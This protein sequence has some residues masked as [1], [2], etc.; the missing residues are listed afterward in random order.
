[1]ERV[2]LSNKGK[3]PKEEFA[4]LVFSWSL[5]D[6]NNEDLYKNRPFDIKIYLIFLTANTGRTDD[7]A[8]VA[9]AYLKYYVGACLYLLITY[10]VSR[11]FQKYSIKAPT[12]LVE[13]IPLSFKSEDNYL[14]S[15]VFPFL[16]ETRAK[17]ASSMEL[18]YKAPFA[19]VIS[20]NECKLRGKLLYDVKVDYWRN[21]TLPGDI[22]VISD[23]KL[24]TISDLQRAGRTWTFASFT[25]IT[26]DENEDDSITT[27]FRIKASEDIEVKD[28]M[29]KSMFVV[30]LINITSSERIWNTLHMS[31]NTKIIKKILCADSVFSYV[32][33]HVEETCDRCYEHNNSQLAERFSTRLLSKLNESQTEA[34]MD[35]LQKMGCSHKTSVKL[36]WGPPGTGKTMTVSTMLFSLLRLNHRILTCAPTNV[37]IKEVASPVLKMV[38]ESFKADSARDSLFC[39]LGDILLFGNEDQLKIGSD[40]EEIY[41]EYHVKRLVECL[42]PLTG[43]KHCLNSMIDFLEDCVSHYHIF[44]EN[45]LFKTK[46]LCEEGEPTEVE[47]KSFLGFARDRFKSTASPL[48]RCLFKFYTNLPKRYILEHNFQN[49]VSLINLLN[50]LEML[51]FQANMVS[52]ELEELL[53]HQETVEDTSEALVETSLLLLCM[54]QSKCLCVLRTLRLSLEELN[55]PSVLNRDSIMEF[56]FQTASLIFCTTSISYKLH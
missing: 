32:L 22:F 24:E 35:S 50:S 33:S 18:L 21:R 11:L 45:E 25:T 31:I 10:L 17:L 30:F 46:K 3:G 2:S 29:W 16:E 12:L 49:M 14:G 40:I 15:Y 9:C 42:G 5:E 48:R 55:L 41:L 47:F 56:C 36:I 54:R 8:V 44:V 20:F 34:I 39:S 1:M 19:E 13:K 23:M 38:K 37:A 53:S 27:H 52:E 26:E 7:F 6:I 28:G 4:D 43:W 51:L